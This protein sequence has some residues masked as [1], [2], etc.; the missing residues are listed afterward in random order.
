M[1][2]DGPES[3]AGPRAAEE[4][5][6]FGLNEEGDGWI[7]SVRRA[8]APRALGS[9]GPYELLEE[10]GR[11]GQGVVFRARQPGTQRVIAIKRLLAGSFA[12]AAARR[13]FE[14]EIEIASELK[15]PNIVTLY[16]VEIVDGQPIL[17]MEWIDGRPVTQ[18]ARDD[19]GR[20]RRREEILRCFLAICAALTHAHQHGV[21]HRDLKPSNVLVDERGEPHLV[22]FGL[23]KRVGPGAREEPLTLSGG[24]AGTPAYASPEQVRGTDEPIDARSD[25][26][27][28]G[29]ILYELLT[30]RLP[31]DA[32]DSVTRMIVAIETEEPRPPSQVVPGIARDLD[33]IVLKALSKDRRQRY[34]SVDALAADIERYLAGEAI[35]AH[36]PSAFYQLRK[37]ARRRW[38]P[39]SAALLLLAL[40]VAY[41]VDRAVQVRRVA[42]ERDHAES[43]LGFFAE[44]TFGRRD[45]WELG[46]LLTLQ[47]ALESGARTIDE[48]FGRSPT[49]A[50]RVHQL[51]GAAWLNL[52]RLAQAEQHVRRA[53]ELEP[54]GEGV[55]AAR[56]DQRLQLLG[57]IHLANMRWRDAVTVAQQLLGLTRVQGDARAQALLLLARA[58]RIAARHAKARERCEQLLQL[59]AQL[60]GERSYEVALAQ[61]ELAGILADAG[62]PALAREHGEHALAALRGLGARGASAA[63]SLEIDLGE[64]SLDEGDARAAC[65][66]LAPALEAQRALLGADHPERA[67]G[68]A[69]RVEAQFAAGDEARAREWLA[70][71][72]RLSRVAL[73]EEHPYAADVLSKLA[74]L[75]ERELDWPAAEKL[76]RDV[77]ERLDRRLGFNN[78]RTAQA[79]ADLAQVLIEE[80]LAG[81]PRDAKEIRTLLETSL[82]S[83][84]DVLGG[85]HPLVAESLWLLGRLEA[86]VEHAP[87][88]AREHLAAART[89]LADAGPRWR[90][91]ARSVD[92]EI[93]ACG[94]P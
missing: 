86:R 21:L 18:W 80:Q 4:I 52:G 87:S 69:V 22:D 31:Y 5:A 45:P 68:V 56:H 82:Q 51:F 44:D 64:I 94:P 26:Y 32:G 93:D 73:D 36:P 43:I 41:A 58:S 92:A 65:E 55:A 6:R 61:A 3:P 88:L 35:L 57:E 8:E 30:A 14:R 33:T 72:E 63:A 17:A 20:P 77:R 7:A 15:H 38:L 2:E 60:H 46:R 39:V 19:G 71:L 27:S 91:L 54:E 16:G 66:R 25:Q 50:A 40:G 48:R 78:P 59:A 24:F 74:A 90:T 70:E 10:E 47:D 53:L 81:T 37:F 29:V 13:R 84:R 12:S 49:D 28:L 75:R 67:P 23:A 79:Q 1:P 11:G 34:A 9:I 89:L 62:E 83:R 42:A 76:Y 85:E